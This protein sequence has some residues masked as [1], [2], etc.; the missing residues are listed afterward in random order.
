MG[1]GKRS[2][3]RIW[4]LCNGIILFR[5]LP[6]GLSGL[7]LPQHPF[8]VIPEIWIVGIHPY[9]LQ[10]MQQIQVMDR[11]DRVGKVQPLQGGIVPTR[12]PQSADLLSV[13]VTDC[14]VSTSRTLSLLLALMHLLLA[15]T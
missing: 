9:A 13:T 12:S 1:F 4:G 5:P 7:Q 10:V 15:I 8:P 11:G 14:Q 6:H 2:R 3:A